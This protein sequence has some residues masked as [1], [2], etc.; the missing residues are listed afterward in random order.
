L[1]EKE[2]F[3]WLRRKLQKKLKQK[4]LWQRD[5]ELLLRKTMACQFRCQKA[6]AEKRAGFES[7]VEN[8]MLNRLADILKNRSQEKPDLEISQAAIKIEKQKR[9]S[10]KEFQKVYESIWQAGPT[11]KYQNPGAKERETALIRQN[12]TQF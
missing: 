7:R 6:L 9:L 8:F 2:Y 3:K 4:K 11:V 1:Q 5:A 12:P 10:N